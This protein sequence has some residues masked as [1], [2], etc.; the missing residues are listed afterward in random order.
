[1][2]GVHA[3]L[4]GCALAVGIAALLGLAFAG[5]VALLEHLARPERSTR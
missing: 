3:F 4:A 5:L 1:M 2:N